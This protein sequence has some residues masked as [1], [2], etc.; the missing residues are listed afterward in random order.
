LVYG[1]RFLVGANVAITKEKKQE[2][3]AQ[4]TE[5]LS[6]LKLAVLTD[7]RGLTVAEIQELRANLR[8]EAITYRVTKN[9]LLKLALTQ[10]EQMKAID[11]AQFTGPMALA[12]GFD[13]EVAPARLVFQYAKTHQALEIVGAITGDGRMLSAGEVKALASLPSREQLLAQVVGTIA[14]PLSSF[15]GVMSGNLRSIL[16]VL[17]AINQT[18]E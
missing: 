3:V 9:T 16:Y 2:A 13:D 7:Y 15:M 14:A 11:L 18:K 8:A 4:L 1:Q 17:N 12:L 6:R 10:T 5:E